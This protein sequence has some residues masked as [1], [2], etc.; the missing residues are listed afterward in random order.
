MSQENVDLMREAYA[1]F[2][3]H[4][5]AAFVALVDDDV[6]VESRLAAMEGTYHGHAGLRRWW[7]AILGAMPD[8]TVEIEELRDLGDVTFAQS[9]G[10]GHGVASA[11]PVI[12]PFWHVV[13]W[14][15]GKIVW[16][17]N[18]STEAEA[19]EAVGLSE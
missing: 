4:D 8:Y 3:R 18:C 17:R 15:N 7:E 19:L 16:W 1:T 11:T 2:N 6:E 5:W 14:K 12:D 9:R 10:L 13:R